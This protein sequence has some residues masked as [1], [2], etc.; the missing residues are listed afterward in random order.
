MIRMVQ[1]SSAGQAREYFNSSLRKSD[2]YLNGQERPGLLRGCVAERLGITGPVTKNTFQALC[3]HINP[4]SGKSLTPRK[5]ENRTVGYDINF[6]CPKSLSIIH[7]LSHDDHILDAFQASVQE[8]MQSIEM[9]A[10]TRVRKHGKDEDRLTGELIWADFIHQTARPVDGIVPD[11][12]LHAHCFVFNVTWD[13]VENE[14]KAGQFRDIKRDMPYYQARFHKIL[15]DKLIALGYCIRRTPTAFEIEG[16]PERVIE[17]FSKRTNEIGRIAQELGITD[18]TKLDQLGARTRAKKQKGLTMTQ[19]KE[20]WRK[21]IHS[22]GMT[23]RGEGDQLI[24]YAAHQELPTL[25]PSD[26]VDHAIKLRFERASV[27]QDRRILETAY[28]HS[29]GNVM[30]TADQI[31]Q[32]FEADQRILKIKDGG[33]TLCTTKEVLDEEQQMVSFA[34]HGQGTLLP[35]Y[36]NPPAIALDGEQH[37]AVAHVLTTPNRVSIIRGRAG[38]GK[39]TLMQEAIRQIEQTGRAVTIVAPTAQAARGVLR[40]EGFTDAE[41]VA[42]LLASPAL[43]AV[44]TNG[45]LWVDEAGLL[46]NADMTALLQLVIKQNARL[47]LSGD[48]QQHT[49]VV[50]GDALRILN[51]VAGIKSAEVSRIYRQRNPAYRKAVQALSQGKA[52]QAFETLNGLGAVKTIDPANP[53]KELAADYVATLKRGK[54]ALVISPT[55]QEGERVTQAIRNKLRDVG[56]IDKTESPALQLVNRNLTQAEKSDARNYQPGQIVQFNQNVSGIKRGERWSVSSVEQGQVT[57]NDGNGRLSILPLDQMAKFDVYQPQEIKLSK[58][59]SI[60][61]TR[62]GFDATKRR[63]NNGQL[64]EVVAVEANG[65]IRLKNTI[66]KVSYTLPN[67]YGHLAYAHC[68]T[69]HAAQGKTVDEVF[70]AQPASTFAAT[71]LNQFYVSVSRA[72]DRVHIYTDDTDGL[73]AR[74]AEVGDRLSALELLKRKRA[75]RRIVEHLVRNEPTTS[76]QTKTDV[77]LTPVL[78]EKP[79]QRKPSAHAP[80]PTF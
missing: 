3:E 80:R 12:H 53:F 37:E 10:Q 52:K 2:Y 55:H 26:C 70:I 9:D 58:G 1:S 64:L 56:R 36:A 73:M 31:T 65:T 20:S 77:K 19:L 66:S 21:Q 57:I 68:I 18:S 4:V 62:N 7:A 54:T 42:Q 14:F 34:R 75:A 59:D 71:S 15:S 48:T 41:T 38:T 17:L 51:T 32:N 50:R 39:T 74:A 63:L 27:M 61:I 29:L 46:N 72:R 33:K 13:A 8:T 5:I 30:V 40:D 44:V 43:Q 45:V 35:L 67:S 28:R 25:T 16:V 69:S 76:S 79:I 24:R 6:H 22:L 11:P 23:D 60:R 49:S 78:V 47:I